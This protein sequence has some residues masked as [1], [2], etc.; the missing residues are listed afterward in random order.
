MTG[1]QRRQSLAEYTEDVPRNDQVVIYD[2][3]EAASLDSSPEAEMTPEERQY[4]KQWD[5]AMRKWKERN[6][7]TLVITLCAAAI[8]TIA[9]YATAPDSKLHLGVLALMYW[10]ASLMW[11]VDGING[12]IEGEGFIE[13]ADTAAML[14]D[15]V[16]GLL[17]VIVGL[18]AWAVYLVA[19]DPKRV[20]RKSLARG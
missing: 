19:K 20:L 12:L 5:A 1:E 13:I 17:V 18:A 2:N 6:A 9:W 14:D 3:A 8:A 7:M 16:L 15:A 11:T 4:W 10:G